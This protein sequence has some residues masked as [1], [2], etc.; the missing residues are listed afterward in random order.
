M[1]AAVWR[2]HFSLLHRKG[3]MA[4]SKVV[5]ANVLRVNR[6]RAFLTQDS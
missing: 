6:N 5:S 2:S 4:C 1:K 3:D